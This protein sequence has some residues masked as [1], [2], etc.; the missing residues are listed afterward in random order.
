MLPA[1]YEILLRFRDL[2]L[3]LLCQDPELAARC[4]QRW[5]ADLA[6]L[7]DADLAPQK[8]AP[9]FST[10]ALPDSPAPATTTLASAAAITQLQP[11]AQPVQPEALPAPQPEQVQ[12]IAPSEPELEAKPEPVTEALP[13]PVPEATEAIP[14][15]SPLPILAQ[16]MPV[17]TPAYSSHDAT[18]RAMPEAAAEPEVSESLPQEPAALAPGADDFEA[19]MNTLMQD[20]DAPETPERQPLKAE[21]EAPAYMNEAPARPEI[22]ADA[23]TELQQAYVSTVATLEKPDMPDTLAFNQSEQT[24][25]ASETPDAEEATL[26]TAEAPEATGDELTPPQPEQRVSD[27]RYI[28]SLMDLVEQ[29]KPQTME[30]S[31]ML[32]TYYL[33]FFDAMSVFNLKH[34]NNLLVKSG[35]GPVN[36]SAIETAID[37]GYLAVVPDLNGTAEMTEYTLSDA[38]KTF[39]ERLL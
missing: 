20:L 37:R 10:P 6:N 26:I 39:T 3:S 14:D 23:T 25:A 7:T 36:H 31:L 28:D 1:R 22:N 21:Y 17:P 5:L 4:V 30:E 11:E 35:Y 34:I 13:L 12:A 29:A 16:S 27:L 38:G 8:T 2:E 19:V 24:P 32:T 9:A 15:A 33:T 18:L